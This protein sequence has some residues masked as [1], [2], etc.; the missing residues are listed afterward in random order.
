M[1][2]RMRTAARDMGAARLIAERLTDGDLSPE[3]ALATTL[4]ED[5]ANGCWQVDAYYS[6]RP[7]LSAVLAAVGELVLAAPPTTLE[8]VPDENWVAVSQ[9]AL[10]P[11]EAGRFLVHGSHDRD[12]SGR[13]HF[14]LEIDAGE[15]FGTAHHAT[16][17]GCLE[18]IDNLA[19]RRHFRR[20]L[21]LGCGS[22][23]LAIA[24][25]RVWPAAAITA[26]DID[27]L[28]VAVAAGNVGLNR[29]KPRIGLVVA[30]G[31]GHQSLRQRGPFDLVVANILAGPLVR[32]APELARQT[33]PGSIVVL[34]GILSEQAR[35]VVAV[36]AAAGFR[37]M[38]RHVRHGW[39]TLTLQRQP[40]APS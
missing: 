28:A 10:P 1:L 35:E 15:A 12:A 25:S 22:G 3:P 18:A 34:S 17:Q 38:L 27:P 37:L 6:E 5:P 20:V 9:A 4:F 30:Q 31:L 32:L 2:I 21:D 39:A 29:A 13:R 16:T 36:Y 14:A 23:V 19:R 24:A 26:S 40:G 33:R 7:D 8:D 11:V